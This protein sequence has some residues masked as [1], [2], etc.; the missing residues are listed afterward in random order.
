ML[1]HQIFG[2][3]CKDIL[4]FISYLLLPIILGVFALVITLQ[5][6]Q[7]LKQ[8]H[9]EDREISALQREQD[10]FFN[11]QKY[12]NELLDTYINDMITLLK[13][14]NGSLTSN[15]ITA[16]IARIKTL[17][18]F[19]QLDAQRNARIIRVLHDAKQLTETQEH[20]ALDLS[21]AKLCDIDFRHMAINE[22]QL[23]E[24][25]LMGVFLSNA[26]YKH[27]YEN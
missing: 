13:E 1:S 9:E 22:K 4:K 8:Q 10:K 3:K 6:Q 2:F 17:D 12:Q 7:L 18:I 15:E 24:L 16:T 25:F 5:Q 21:T 11:D 20:S 19:R 23:H 14:S 26:S 27:G